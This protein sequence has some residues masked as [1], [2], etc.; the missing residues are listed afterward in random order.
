MTEALLVSNALLWVLVVALGLVVVALTRQIGLLHERIAPVGAL[1]TS[2]GLE[3]GDAVPG[4]GLQTLDGAELQLA[5]QRTLLFFLSPTCPVCE[6]ILPTL[7]RI[8]RE[9]AGG[10]RVILASDGDPEEHGR[11]ALEKQ[12]D[13]S[14]YV[15]SRELGLRFEV[16][17]LPYAVL[18]DAA[19]QVAAK[20]IVNTREHIESLFEAERLRVGSIQ[21]FLQQNDELPMLELPRAGAES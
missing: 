8:E 11:F 17:K 3:V 9:E 5:A 12:L 1:A 18:I 16:A 13:R 6:T 15:L 21:E 14:T 4:F 20:G 2:A 19:G 10:L 7:Q